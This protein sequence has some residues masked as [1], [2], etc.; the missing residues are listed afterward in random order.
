MKRLAE[1]VHQPHKTL[2]QTGIT[3]KN[4]TGRRKKYLIHVRNDVLKDNGSFFVP[5]KD[6]CELCVAYENADI[7]DKAKLEEK[8]D[9]H[10]IEKILSRKEKKEGKEAL[11]TNK[12]LIV[13]V[14]D[15]QAVLQLPRGDVSVF[16]YRSKL[17]NMNF[18]VSKLKTEERGQK[19]DHLTASNS[20]ND[21]PIV[22][23]S[24]T[25]CYFW[26]EGVGNR[27]ADEI[28][29]CS[30]EFIEKELQSHTSNEP[31]DSIFYSD[32]CCGQNK[33]KYIV[34]MFM[35]AVIKHDKLN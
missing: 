12:N 4:K 28:G 8:Y 16:Y 24:T 21:E 32:N 15:L 22:N 13:A 26:H 18:T 29:S 25:K 31:I 10:L 23:L 14:Y 9:E 11:K 27:G 1:A 17:N 2:I 6:R 19:R 30:F 35:Y 3:P 20:N 7:A 33:N 34:E 5:K